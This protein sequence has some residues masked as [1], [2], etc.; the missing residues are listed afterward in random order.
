MENNEL[1]QIW[2][3]IGGIF[4]PFIFLSFFFWKLIFDN[5][6]HEIYNFINFFIITYLLLLLKFVKKLSFIETNKD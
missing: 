1:H 2:C 6:F 5:K 4:T 3:T